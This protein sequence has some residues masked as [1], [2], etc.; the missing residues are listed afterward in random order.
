MHSTSALQEELELDDHKL[1]RYD[2]VVNDG[3]SEL[4]RVSSSGTNE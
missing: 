1:E 2:S 3:A 4:V